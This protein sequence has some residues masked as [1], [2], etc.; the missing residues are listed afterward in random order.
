[1]VDVGEKKRTTLTIDGNVLKTAMQ[2]GI[3]VSQF[4][5]NALKEAII[6]LQTQNNT[7]NNNSAP[8]SLSSGSL[9]KRESD[10]EPSAGFGPATITLPR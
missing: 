1:M 5:E 3:N 4:C 7:L 6:K 2:I 10:M 9:S 8:I